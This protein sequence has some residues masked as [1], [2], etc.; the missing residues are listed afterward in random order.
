ME[1]WCWESKITDVHK[2]YVVRINN[3]Y[4]LPQ[5]PSSE[6]SNLENTISQVPYLHLL[7]SYF[8]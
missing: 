5:L 1:E 4:F 3:D 7:K 2:S 6:I 8:Y